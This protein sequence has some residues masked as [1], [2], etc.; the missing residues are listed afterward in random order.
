MHNVV[1]EKVPGGKLVRIKVESDANITTLQITGD[2]FLYPESTIEELE[3][4]IIGTPTSISREELKSRL[5]KTIKNHNIAL[6]GV[7]SDDLARMTKQ[8][9]AG[10]PK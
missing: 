2:F 8:A 9:T 4:T 5:D 7:T 1:T 6:V 3:K 10:A